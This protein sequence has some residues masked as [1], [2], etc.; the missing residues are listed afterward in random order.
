VNRNEAIKTIVEAAKWLTT[1][2]ETHTGCFNGRIYEIEVEAKTNDFTTSRRGIYFGRKL[3]VRQN[4]VIQTETAIVLIDH[5]DR[6]SWQD[7]IPCSYHVTDEGLRLGVNDIMQVDV[8][9][10]SEW[11]DAKLIRMA[12]NAVRVMNEYGH[13]VAA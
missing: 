4:R 3:E 8:R 12:T 13:N 9:L 5:G 1:A 11:D 2:R 7:Y 6:A 10:L